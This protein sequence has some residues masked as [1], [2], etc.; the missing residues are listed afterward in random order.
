MSTAQIMVVEDESLIAE[1][2]RDSLEK[3]GYEV[4]QT[5]ATGEEAVDGA[6][7][8]E[9]DLI[10]M[11]IML[12]GELDG[13]EAAELIRKENDIPIIFL[14]SF[15]D[16][17]MLTRAKLATPLGYLVKPFENRELRATIEMALYKH[18]A[19]QERERLIRELEQANAEIKKLRG[20]LPICAY[21]KKI[22]N[23]EG[24]WNEVEVY[25]RDH[26][27]AKFSHGICP[28]CYQR[29]MKRLS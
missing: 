18:R 22:R 8:L 15:A 5:V 17:T 4:C 6:L 3:L 29:E 14:S 9:P 24:Y 21:C 2:I 7:D 16:D 13:I 23:D 28:D 26:S 12:Q 10:L 20:I 1:D 27:E 25:I 19:D 11:D